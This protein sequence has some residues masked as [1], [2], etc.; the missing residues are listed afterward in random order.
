MVQGSAP[1]TT[2]KIAAATRESVTQLRTLRDRFLADPSTDLSGVREVI[3]RSWTRSAACHVNP[4]H[5]YSEIRDV[6]LDGTFLRVAMPIVDRLGDMARDTGV[7][8]ILSDAH[9]THAV[10]RGD[11]DI[12]R[13]ADERL[14]F[15]GG[16]MPEDLAGTN[17][18]GTALEE[19]RS[20]Q[21]WGPEHYSV[22]LQDTYCT[23]VPI[24]DAVRGRI[25]AV[26]TLMVPER[27]A[28]TTD[29]AAIALIVEGAAAEIGRLVGD[30]LGRRE[31][32]LLDAYIRESRTRGTEGVVAID[33][34]TT[35]ASTR[36]QQLLTPED[37]AVVSGYAN[38]VSSRGVSLERVVDFGDLPFR[39]TARPVI[40]DGDVVGAVVRF[41]RQADSVTRGS[42]DMA[43]TPAPDLPD[44]IGDSSLMS[45]VRV[46]AM[47]AVRQE[48]TTYITGER[49]TGRTHLARLMLEAAG[50]VDLV[51]L[52]CD[53]ARQSSSDGAMVDRVARAADS[54]YP[55][56][57]RHFDQLDDA[58]RA[59]MSD[60]LR[61]A[62]ER[63]RLFFTANHV[64]PESMDDVS[65]SAAQEI[66]LPPLRSRRE[67]IPRLVTHFLREAM[68]QEQVTVSSQLLAA[69]AQA[70]WPGNVADLREVVTSAAS[71]RSGNVIDLADLGELQQKK[72][73]RGRLTRLE[74]AELEQIRHALI[75]SG[76]NRA[77]AAQLLGIGRS[78]LY[79]KIE[80]YSRRGFDLGS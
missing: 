54:G 48:S 70:D 51:V 76:G 64:G 22:A 66:R 44:L 18:D 12:M 6:Q 4:E 52:E 29:P 5:V 74:A 24:R 33:G 73:A 8:I 46:A 78:T 9:G 17:S 16:H 53:P 57:L 38:E 23:S 41:R 58:L 19:G 59:N 34:R 63:S 11:R 68:P 79:R 77:R 65:R 14:A 50:A 37:H 39:L 2:G 13:W 75:E 40:A 3:A 31:R 10:M 49:G 28:L 56:I 62:A 69:L 20:V 80:L 72:I 55:I 61:T 67:D 60:A 32:A 45:S 26:L 21:V 71:R 36:A 25:A 47:A 35:I 30:R 1:V 42:S 43:T 7:C 27:V 15:V